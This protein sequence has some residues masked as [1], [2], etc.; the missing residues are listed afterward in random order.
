MHLR[1]DTNN[2]IFHVMAEA[3]KQKNGQNEKKNYLDFPEHQNFIR[4]IQ[5]NIRYLLVN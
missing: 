5:N 2:F 3:K 1:S 4:K